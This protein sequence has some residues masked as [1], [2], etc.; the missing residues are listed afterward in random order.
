MTVKDLLDEF[1]LEIDDVRWY[2]A[3]YMADKLLSYRHEPEMLT[4]YIWSGEL[5]GEF[6]NMEE[7]LISD[8]Q[9][10]L[11]RDM[12]DEI[13]LRELMR[14]MDYLRIRRQKKGF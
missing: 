12:T 11:D 7:R 8:L 1:D 10:Q 9:D 4:R 2:M 6:Y 5:E 13:R 3:S 14:E